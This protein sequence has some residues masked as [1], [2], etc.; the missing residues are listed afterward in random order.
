MIKFTRRDFLKVSA[1]S[2]CSLVIST[3][4]TGCSSAVNLTNV[5]F[6]HGVASGDPLTNSVIIWTRL[7]PDDYI[8]ELKLNYEVSKSSTFDVL[9]HSGI[10]ST[11]KTEDY[12]VKIDLQNLEENTVYY[13]RFKSN[14]KTSII[15]KTKTLSSSPSQV[16]FAVFS[17]SNYTNG[18]F[19]AY[20]D[21][22]TLE[23]IDVVLHLGDYIYEYGM[24]DNDDGI[25]PAYATQNASTIGRVLPEDNNT[26]LLTLD[27]YR[28]RYAL[29]HTDEGSL[30]IHKNLP[31]ITI[32]DDHEVAN[33]AY[34][35]GAENH[36]TTEGDYETRKLDALKAYFEW[37]PI[38]PF[39]KDNEEIIYRSFDFGDLVSLHMLDTRIIGRDI[40][41][42]YSNYFDSLG[43]FDQSSF[44]TDMSD[45][46]RTMLG[47][48]QL[49]WL[50]SKLISSSATWQV[51]G[52]Q[53]LAGKMYLPAELLTLIVKLNSD[54]TDVE[55]ISVLTQL[56]TILS[57]LVS[58]KTRILQ[59]DITLTTLEKA[60]VTTTLPYNLDSW[61]GY[62]YEREILYATIRSLGKNVVVLA[63]D[64]HNSWANE[65]KD[66]NGNAIAVEFAT[67]SVTSPGMEE[68]VGLANTASSIQFEAAITLLVDDLKYTNLN[69]R[70]YMLLTFTKDEVLTTWNYLDNTDSTTY[71]LDTT[72]RKQ[73]KSLV[74]SNTISEIV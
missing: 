70:G 38:R 47:S 2:F 44:L 45:T 33:D 48:E 6:I 10:L 13:Y 29:Y 41:L 65:L 24:Y 51:L 49:A 57:E 55:K 15:G 31:F 3:G 28:K 42:N 60:R 25:T 1:L 4:V 54:L 17:C 16:K 39:E 9:T 53:V 32:W 40:Q 23:D 56:N 72:R 73:L 52:Q 68:Y 35:D 71:T 11:K 22:S 69:Q 5:S 12:T 46:S 50:Q 58:I 62:A 37:L 43:T 61:D 26:E 74:G 8:P 59:G 19:N 27:D 7:T 30:S 18:Y 14:E 67:T 66:T 34:K 20:K 21:V 64:T 36:D 63:G